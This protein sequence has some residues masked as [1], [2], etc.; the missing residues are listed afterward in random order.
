LYL[1]PQVL[2]SLLDQTIYSA[3]GAKTIENGGADAIVAMAQQLH[4]EVM[5]A[6]MP[7]PAAT[8]AKEGYWPARFGHLTT[9]GAT[10]YGYLFN[11]AYAAQLWK[12]QFVAD[13]LH[14][15]GGDCLWALLRPGGAADP[16]KLLADALGGQAPDL[17]PYF[18]E[19]GT[20]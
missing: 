1:A 12:H 15:K 13:P 14:P 16:K 7:P 2:L 9:Y 3:E 8:S 11:K 20:K 18:Q 10:Y 4:R 5:P 19:M 17:N 6:C